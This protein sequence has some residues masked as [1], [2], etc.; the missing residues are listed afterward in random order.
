MICCLPSNSALKVWKN[1][2][3]VRSLPAKNWMSSISSASTCW[4]WRL[5]WSIAFSCSAF[6]IA[7]KN[8]SER[9]YSTRMR[10]VVGA[11]QVA[12]GVHQV[13]LAQPGAAVQQQRVVVAR[14]GSARPAARRRG[15]AGCCGLRRSSRR[16][17]A[18]SRLPWNASAL[19]PATAAAR[20][21][22]ASLAAGLAR[23]QRA[24]LEADFGCAGEMRQQFA[25][26]GQVALAHGVDHEGIGGVKHRGRRRAARPAGA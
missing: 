7:L 11:H 25:D 1:S 9:R 20:C 14:P 23:G 5:N 10:R 19:A 22:A 16:C 4:N 26:A 15:R 24:D 6:I 17:S 12:G 13:G 3:W 21:I 8:C 2:S 18:L